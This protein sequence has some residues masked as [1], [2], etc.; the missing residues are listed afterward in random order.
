MTNFIV[1][2][3]SL[4]LKT[5]CMKQKLIAQ[6]LFISKSLLWS[7]LFYLAAMTIINWEE[8]SPNKKKENGQSWVKKNNQKELIPTEVSTILKWLKW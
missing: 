5:I 8:L 1:C 2:I 3:G 6:T 4:C 7:V